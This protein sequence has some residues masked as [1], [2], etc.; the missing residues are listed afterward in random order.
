VSGAWRAIAEHEIP[1][2]LVLAT[3]PPHGDQNRAHIGR[4]QSAVPHAE[5]RWA[6][7]AGHG[8]LA[9]VGPPLGEDIASWL[10]EQ[11]L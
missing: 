11:G 1:T 6:D 3:E 10:V 8:L 7:G 9:D 4:F 5:I 2:L